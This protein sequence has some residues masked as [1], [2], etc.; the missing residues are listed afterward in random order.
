MAK[1]LA[2]KETVFKKYIF[3]DWKSESGARV[4]NMYVKGI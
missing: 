3:N 4:K 2:I 1:K